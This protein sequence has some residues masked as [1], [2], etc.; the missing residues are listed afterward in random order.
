MKCIITGNKMYSAYNGKPI[1][2]DVVCFARY[3]RS[4]DKN[5][6]IKSIMESFFQMNMEGFSWPQ[7]K[8]R[9]ISSLSTRGLI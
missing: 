3:Y 1:S 4:I 6:K 9:F 2:K 5:K 8:D 7:I